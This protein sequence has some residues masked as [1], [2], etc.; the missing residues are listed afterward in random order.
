MRHILRHEASGATALVTSGFGFNL[1]SL[2][3]MLGGR[4]TELLAAGE[5]FDVHRREPARHGIPILFPFPNRIEAGHY[6]FQ[7][8]TYEIPHP[9][10]PHA[11]HGFALDSEWEVR[12]YVPSGE[13]PTIEGVF[14]ISKHA[15]ARLS[16]W[17]ADGELIVRYT[18]YQSGLECRATIVG[19]GP[20]AFPFGLGFHPYFV[21][22]F[23]PEGDP[24]NTLIRVPAARRWQLEQNLPTGALQLPSAQE[25]LSEGQPRAALHL[26]DV[27][28]DLD[29]SQG[30]CTCA[31]LDLSLQEGVLL[32]MEPGYREVV[33]YTPPHLPE[34]IAVEPYTCTTNAINLQARGLDA[35]L[36]VLAPGESASFVWRLQTAR[37][38]GRV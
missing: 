19:R 36:R 14:H 15:P 5:D 38:E 3:L 4:L 29:F 11:N 23:H 17:P 16:C 28:T 27:Y 13:A 21:L 37:L 33:V 1:F 8:T 6:T 7:G 10:K 18:L 35:G 22:P 20:G 2:K 32:S 25:Q 9:G 24:Q 30:S 12:E 34:V 31:L 26:D